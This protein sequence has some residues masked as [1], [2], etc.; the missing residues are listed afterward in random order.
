[1]GISWTVVMVFPSSGTLTLRL[2]DK[3]PVRCQKGRELSGGRAVSL[4]EVGERPAERA[5][6]LSE[7]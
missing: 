5:A 6:S 7:A 3:E 1:M 4:R 2:L